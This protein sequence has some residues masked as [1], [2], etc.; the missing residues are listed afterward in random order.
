MEQTMRPDYETTVQEDTLPIEK[1]VVIEVMIIDL[2]E[3]EHLLDKLAATASVV[4]EIRQQIDVANP[5]ELDALI[6]KLD[7]HERLYFHFF[8]RLRVVYGKE[9]LKGEKFTTP[10]L[11]ARG[12]NSEYKL[13]P[14]TLKSDE[15]MRYESI[16][17]QEAN[18]NA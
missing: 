5:A 13:E 17:F 18:Q 3:R 9:P 16:L 10:E 2:E 15:H 14:V 1:E 12:R 6:I 8:N 11:S 7:A 4:K